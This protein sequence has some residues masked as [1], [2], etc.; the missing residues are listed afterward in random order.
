MSEMYYSTI[1]AGPG[2]SRVKRIFAN[3]DQIIFDEIIAYPIPTLPM[4]LASEASNDDVAAIGK[5]HESAGGVVGGDA[6][7]FRA[8]GT[9]ESLGPTYGNFPCGIKRV[10]DTLIAVWVIAP[11]RYFER[12]ISGGPI[13]DFTGLVTS[14][15]F[16]GF[17]P[18]GTPRWIDD[19]RSVTINGVLLTLPTPE[20]NGW[21]AGQSNRFYGIEAVH[22]DGRA[23]CV[24]GSGDPATGVHVQTGP[25]MV[26]NSYGSMEVCY[27]YEV[28]SGHDLFVHENDWLPVPGVPD[29][30]PTA[31]PTAPP[32]RT[33]YIKPG[34]RILLIGE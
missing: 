29:Q 3:R 16:S 4:F 25:Q 19:H 12:N 28:E 13:S 14:Q 1:C 6:L 5:A 11:G 30:P 17:L 10:G 24:V 23:R 18:D 2:K 31:P 20:I 15:G 9:F 27:S 21:V 26:M 33:I 7:L 8:D 22:R 34:E 32:T